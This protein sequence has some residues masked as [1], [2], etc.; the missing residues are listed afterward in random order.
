MAGWVSSDS[1]ITRVISGFSPFL[2]VQVP[3]IFDGLVKSQNSRV[4]SC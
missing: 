2:I 1:T 3:N 4:L